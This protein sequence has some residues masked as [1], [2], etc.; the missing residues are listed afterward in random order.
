ME[1]YRDHLYNPSTYD[2][3]SEDLFWPALIAGTTAWGI[4]GL[5][6][7]RKMAELEIQR[8]KLGLKKRGEKFED[9]ADAT[10]EY[11]A[12]FGFPRKRKRKSKDHLYKPK[13]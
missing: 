2:S 10:N 9:A 1:H 7:K 8:Q 11:D 13:R 12:F 6:H 4:A 3:L 5:H